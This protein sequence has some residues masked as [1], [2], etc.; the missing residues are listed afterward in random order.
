M[1][2]LE[3]MLHWITKERSQTMKFYAGTDG[4]EHVISFLD[5]HTE[6]VCPK[7]GSQAEAFDSDEGGSAD[8]FLE[9]YYRC[10]CGEE[11]T[12]RF[13]CVPTQLHST[14]K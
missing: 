6:G 14:T 2:N 13:Y 4:T 1:Q 9:H 3:T 7:C 8:H 5:G 10:A 12:E 11:F